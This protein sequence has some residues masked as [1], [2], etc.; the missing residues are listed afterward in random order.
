MLVFQK[1]TGHAGCAARE[2]GGS[3]GIMSSPSNPSI[4]RI[5]SGGHKGVRDKTFLIG[6]SLEDAL[7]ADADPVLFSGDR[8]GTGVGSQEE[9]YMAQ[10]GPSSDSHGDRKA[11]LS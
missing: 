10:V 4:Y 6:C 3:V 7:V 5:L 8:N 9:R 11:S 1:E 2:M